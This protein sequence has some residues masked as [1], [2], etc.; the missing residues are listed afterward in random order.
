MSFSFMISSFASRKPAQGGS[1]YSRLCFWRSSRQPIPLD[2][3][4]LAETVLHFHGLAGDL[5]ALLFQV[6]DPGREPAHTEPRPGVELRDSLAPFHR[7]K[8]AVALAF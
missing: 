1:P 6:V 8:N 2:A 4:F 3:A 5:D 7:F